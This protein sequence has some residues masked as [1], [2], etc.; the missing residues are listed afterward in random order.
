MVNRAGP[1]HRQELREY[2]IDLLR[3]G[4]EVGDAPD[5]RPVA[6]RRTNANPLGIGLLLMLVGLPMTLLFAPM[7]L[8]LLGIGIGMSIWG[9]IAVI[10]RR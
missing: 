9:V 4:T 8:G 2:A 6:S 1:E 10:V 7:G 5:P 3:D